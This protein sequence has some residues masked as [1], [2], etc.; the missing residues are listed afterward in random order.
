MA[1]DGVELTSV[2]HLHR[3]LTVERIRRATMLAALRGRRVETVE[4]RQ[5]AR[6]GNR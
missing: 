5:A 1:L 4:V 3:L 2:D 6:L